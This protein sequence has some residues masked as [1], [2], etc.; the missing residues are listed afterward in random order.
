MVGSNIGVAQPCL[1]EPDMDF[2]GEEEELLVQGC[3]HVEAQHKFYSATLSSEPFVTI[4]SLG[5]YVSCVMIQAVIT[6]K[7]E[8]HALADMSNAYIG[9]R[10]SVRFN[11]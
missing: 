3:I 9:D 10:T 11:R 1:F 5:L 7:C 8:H 4:G 6:P 2:R